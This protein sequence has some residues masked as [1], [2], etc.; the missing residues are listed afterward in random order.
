V[1]LDDV[2]PDPQYRMC[3]SRVI[4]ASSRVVWDELHGITMSALPLGR[5]LEAVRLLPARL[6]GRKHQPLADRSFLDVT[7]FRSC[8]RS[9]LMS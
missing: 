8:S 6:A 4:G 5:A 1:N 7:P 9:D 2:I 3:H